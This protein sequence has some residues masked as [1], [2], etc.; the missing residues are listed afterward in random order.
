MLNIYSVAIKS[1]LHRLVVTGEYTLIGLEHDIINLAAGKEQLGGLTME[2]LSK[3]L[4]SHKDA[5]EIYFSELGKLSVG[6]KWFITFYPVT[7]PIIP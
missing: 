3:I 5:L 4:M 6:L 2:M 7:V 1:I